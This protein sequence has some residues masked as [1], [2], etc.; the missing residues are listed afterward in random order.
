MTTYYVKNGGSDSAAGTS[1]GTAWETIA[2]VNSEMGNFNAGDNIYFKRGST[3]TGN[4]LEITCSGSVGNPITFGAYDSG[5]EPSIGG[6]QVATGWT[7]HTADVGSNNVDVY[8]KTYAFN[9]YT[10]AEDWTFLTYI[11]WDTDVAT[12][13]AAA[14]SGSWSRSG[15]TQ[16]VCCT[17][18][19]DPDTHTMTS[20]ASD[21]GYD[22]NCCWVGDDCTYVTIENIEFLMP[23]REGIRVRNWG[24]NNSNNIILDAVETYFCGTTG[25][26]IANDTGGS[27]YKVTD[28]TIQNCI[29]AYNAYHG[30]SIR[31]RCEDVT[32]TGCTVS[33]NGWDREDG[34]D[35]WGGHGITM[36]GSTSDRAPTS[37][38]IEHNT[39]SYIFAEQD[40]GE[41][42]GI[43]F[44]NN[45]NN[46]IARYNL[47]HHCEG[48]GILW[49]SP[50]NTAYYNLIY[51][52]VTGN[53]IYTGGLYFLNGT[54][55]SA[56]NNVVYNCKNGATF[57][58]A[59]GETVTCKNNIIL[60]SSI[61]DYR[62]LWEGS[63]YGTIV[64]DYN[65]IYNSTVALNF[66]DW[67]NGSGDEQ[68]LAEWQ[69]DTGQDANSTDSDPSLLDVANADFRP[70]GDS[71]CI[72]AGTDVGLTEDYAGV[73]V[74]T[75]G[76]IE[77]GAYEY[78]PGMGATLSPSSAITA[79]VG[80]L[81]GLAGTSAGASATTA[82]LSDISEPILFTATVTAVSSLSAG[83]VIEKLVGAAAATSS[84]IAAL[85]TAYPEDI[86]VLERI[87]N[88][89][90]PSISKFMI[91]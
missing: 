83:Q 82:T 42:T 75:G 3:W 37:C 77:I 85:I 49:N 70:D 39:V 1:D 53:G 40:G 2:K 46:C 10:L 4:C 91:T 34:I 48:G 58:V 15:F 45:T 68:D 61:Y 88:W 9:N 66:L 51:T 44:D 43:Q 60:E 74:P 7:L 29:S 62:W 12:T 81:R 27:T 59:T 31:G 17:D 33:Y 16:Y 23:N 32:V 55:N 30:I 6:W 20:G 21:T 90:Y 63:G 11:E 54:G 69:T 19:L 65:C 73:T 71:P 89:P 87:R 79:L 86:T 56:Y 18:D 35:Q 38:T 28:I 36:Y 22:F 72:S 80:F 52:C 8:Y 50:N 25:I 5:T 41:G 84:A 14:S 67:H 13:F 78:I 26:Q 64:S 24:S 76:G 57:S 47:I